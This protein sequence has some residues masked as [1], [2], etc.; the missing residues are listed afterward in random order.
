M[1]LLWWLGY[2]PRRVFAALR[3]CLS[4]DKPSGT[5]SIERN[6]RKLSFS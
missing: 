3:L 6:A 4:L 5:I 2:L 1:A